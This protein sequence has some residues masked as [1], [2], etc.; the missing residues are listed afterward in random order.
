VSKKRNIVY[1]TNPNYDYD[2]KN[3]ELETLDPREQKLKVIIDRK[4]RKGKSVTIVTGFKGS[5]NDLKDLAKTLKSKCGG[6][7]SA[8]D[9]EILVQG[10]FKDK[11]YS[12]L[13]DMG[14]QQTKKVG[15]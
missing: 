13:I 2:D 10:E 4:Q 14:Y 15:G 5:D 8:K 12:I 6:G 11:I 3:E 1:S 7:G 9:Q